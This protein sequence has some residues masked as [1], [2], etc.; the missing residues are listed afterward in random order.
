[1]HANLNSTGSF[2]RSDDGNYWSY[3]TKMTDYYKGEFFKNASYYSTT[4]SKHQCRIPY[5]DFN[6]QLKVDKLGDW[7]IEDVIKYNID[8]IRA[9]NIHRVQKRKTKNSLECIKANVLKIKF[10]RDLLQE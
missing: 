9:E 4:T 1:M 8:K 5:V 6:H 10:L 7:N 2:W 3:N